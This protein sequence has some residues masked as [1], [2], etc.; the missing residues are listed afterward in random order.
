[1]VSSKS[2][3]L[4]LEEVHARLDRMFVDH[5]VALTAL[6]LDGARRLLRQFDREIRA[7]IRHEEE[8]LLPVY[9]ERATFDRIGEP[10][11]FRREHRK[12]E[13]YLSAFGARMDG[14]D[15]EDPEI[16]RKIIELLDEER[17]LKEVLRHHGEREEK[18]LYPKLD[19][20]CSDEERNR[21]MAAG[22]GPG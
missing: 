7:H 14:L 17:M 18:T 20:L 21:M 8:V 5:Q 10:D 1:M 19:E 22:E 11:L 2:S 15:R 3:F 16:R 6:D 13:A 9:G 4:Q 12:I